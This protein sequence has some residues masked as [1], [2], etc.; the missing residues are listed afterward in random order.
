MMRRRSMHG[1]CAQHFFCLDTDGYP[2]MRCDKSRE[3][4][5]S[6]SLCSVTFRDPW[7]A[8]FPDHATANAFGVS[9]S[10]GN[11]HSSR[12]ETWLEQHF[13]VTDFL[14]QRLPCSNMSA[15]LTF[16]SGLD[17]CSALLI[18]RGNKQSSRM[19]FPHH[20][21]RHRPSVVSR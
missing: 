9:R 13:C 5:L 2:E 12:A 1:W 18:R 4:A 15:V 21:S 3:Y 11:V 7:R 6:L 20:S 8:S 16:V 17:H 10:T 19:F 14:Q